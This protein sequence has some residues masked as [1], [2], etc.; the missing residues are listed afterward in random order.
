[1][2]LHLS[3]WQSHHFFLSPHSLLEIS[4]NQIAIFECE[5]QGD[6]GFANARKIEVVAALEDRIREIVGFLN[7]SLSPI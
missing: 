7:I 1:M 4:Q 5:Q 6:F 3:E 2:P